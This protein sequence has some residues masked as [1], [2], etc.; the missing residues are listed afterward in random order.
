MYDDSRKYKCIVVEAC[1]G[2]GY[3]YILRQTPFAVIEDFRHR[4]SDFNFSRITEVMVSISTE[5]V[6]TL[7]VENLL[8]TVPLSTSPLPL[9]IISVGQ[10]YCRVG[11][12]GWSNHL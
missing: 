3:S 11:F 4:F 9:A 7:Y 8:Q 10:S 1:E 6:F 5:H 2:A 12:I